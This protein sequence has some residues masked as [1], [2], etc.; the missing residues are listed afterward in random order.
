MGNQKSETNKAKLSGKSAFPFQ[1]ETD[2]S[3]STAI[4]RKE[5]LA[6]QKCKSDF[7]VDTD[8]ET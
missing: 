5:F 2:G 4:F 6:G 1:S 3:Q 8:V 7:L